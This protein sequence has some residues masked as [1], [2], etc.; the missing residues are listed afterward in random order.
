M[1]DLGSHGLPTGTTNFPL[2]LG[3]ISYEFDYFAGSQCLVYFEQVLVEDCVR[4]AWSVQQNRTPVYGY[5]SQYYNALGA[6]VIMVTGSFF[7]AFKEA[8]YIP[9]ILRH[10]SRTQDLM[11]YATP[12]LGPGRVRGLHHAT[13]LVESAVEWEAVGGKDTEGLSGA[14][15]RLSIER[16]IQAAA[17]SPDDPEVQ[18]ELQQL[19][20]Q[21]DAIDDQGFEDIAERFEDA[22][23]YGGNERGGGRSEL[24][25]GNFAGGEMTEL[26][27]AAIRRADQFP[28]FDIIVTFGDIN[29]PESNHTLHR[30]MDVSIV[31]TEFGGIEPTGEPIYVRYDF[32]ARNVA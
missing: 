12:A 8:A 3:D 18:A 32:I 23:W 17:L 1:V 5:A 30:I 9:V 4:I 13:G 21:L 25:S 20:L 10:V 27:R 14:A 11:E 6:G 15:Q 31:N 28:P 19:A 29:T 22:L 7:I 16:M 26:Q 2:G 24:T